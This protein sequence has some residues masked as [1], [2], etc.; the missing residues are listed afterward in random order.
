M[1]AQTRVHIWTHVLRVWSQSVPLPSASEVNGEAEWCDQTLTTINSHHW[2]KPPKKML[3][4]AGQCRVT[5]VQTTEDKWRHQWLNHLSGNWLSNETKLQRNMLTLS[6]WCG[7]SSKCLSRDEFL[8]LRLQRT[9]SR[10]QYRL[11]A[12]FE[13]FGEVDD[14]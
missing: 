4:N 9:A 14:L 8:G 10:S 12:E 6:S 13:A 1:E 11:G 3:R 5:V 7:N 2:L